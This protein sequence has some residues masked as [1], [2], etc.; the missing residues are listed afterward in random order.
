[1]ISSLGAA[2]VFVCFRFPPFALRSICVKLRLNGEEGD[3]TR[4]YA[5]PSKGEPKSREKRE[6][7]S[8]CDET[9]SFCKKKRG[10]S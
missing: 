2:C 8:K 3:L 1:M 6:V 7:E 5:R 4:F 10:K 9:E